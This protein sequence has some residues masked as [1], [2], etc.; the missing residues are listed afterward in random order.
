MID[1]FDNKREW[2][3]YEVIT[4]IGVLLGW[5]KQIKLDAVKTNQATITIA[6][7]PIYYLPDILSSAY[8]FSSTEIITSGF[9][10]L[11]VWTGTEKRLNQLTIGILERF[12]IVK[13]PWCQPNKRMFITPAITDG[14]DKNDTWDD[15]EF[16]GST[17]PR[18]PS[19]KPNDSAENEIP[20]D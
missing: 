11:I 8:E 5:V 13:L 18:R 15:D 6:I 20:L 4:E 12:N 16:S 14:N 2:I 7:I 17:K 10:S 19:P 1:S 9:N 3:G